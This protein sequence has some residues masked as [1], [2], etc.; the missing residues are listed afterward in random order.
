MTDA[1]STRIRIV[2]LCSLA[3]VVLA[4]YTCKIGPQDYNLHLSKRRAQSVT[5]YLSRNFNIESS[6]IMRY[7]YGVTNPKADNNTSDG[8]ARNRRVEIAVGGLS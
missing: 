6:R 5:D 2:G 8:R 4:G 7:W 3:F 1:R